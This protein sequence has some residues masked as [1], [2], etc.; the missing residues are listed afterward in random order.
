MR[1]MDEN[2]H[3]G[4]FCCQQCDKALSG[5]SYILKEEKPFCVACYD[6][7]FAN[8]CAEC[9]QKIGHDS[10]VRSNN[11]TVIKKKEIVE[12]YNIFRQNYKLN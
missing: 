10:K 3:S 4:H 7:N 6:D 11:I 9:N 2:F 1:A 5:Q 12:P 8:E